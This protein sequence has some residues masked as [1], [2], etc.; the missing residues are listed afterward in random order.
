VFTQN[1]A[2]VVS[3]SVTGIVTPGAL[4]YNATV[5]IDPAM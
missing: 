3:Y 4:S 5:S 2:A 1:G